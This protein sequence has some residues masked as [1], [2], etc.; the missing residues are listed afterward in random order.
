MTGATSGSPA[1]GTYSK[2]LEN[3]SLLPSTGSS[4][5]RTHNS[6]SPARGSKIKEVAR[7]LSEGEKDGLKKS[8]VDPAVAMSHLYATMS[9]EMAMADEIDSEVP[10]EGLFILKR[11]NTL[12]YHGTAAAR[13]LLDLQHEEYVKGHSNN[14]FMQLQ[15][16]LVLK[17]SISVLAPSTISNGQQPKR[18]KLSTVKDQAMREAFNNVLAQA[19]NEKHPNPLKFTSFKTLECELASRGFKINFEGDWS[20]ANFEN[21]Y[22]S[23]RIPASQSIIEAIKGNKITMTAIDHTDAEVTSADDAI[24]EATDADREITMEGVIGETTREDASS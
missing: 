13:R 4:T 22:K 17:D 24:A 12:C 2:L 23:K 10:I 11:G 21:A 20:W 5:P 8:A 9:A 6:L 18:P 3:D 15:S 14:I 19:T 7:S 16:Y 1:T